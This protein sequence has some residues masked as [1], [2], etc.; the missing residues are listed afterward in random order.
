MS[1]SNNS[2]PGQNEDRLREIMAAPSIRGPVAFRNV[3]TPVAAAAAAPR[4]IRPVAAIAPGGAGAFKPSLGSAFKK[5][6]TGGA[7][8]KKWVK[9][10]R[11]R[12]RH[13]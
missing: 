12:R 11:S 9:K 5:P 2:A 3:S 6:G 1:N 13:H 10:L 4:A 8:T 7:R